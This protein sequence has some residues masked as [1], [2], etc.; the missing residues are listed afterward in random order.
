VVPPQAL[1]TRERLFDVLAQI[2]PVVFEG[3]AAEQLGRPDGVIVLDGACPDALPGSVPALLTPTLETQGPAADSTDRSIEFSSSK[4]VA[5]ALR[6]RILL[7]EQPRSGPVPAFGEHDEALAEVD[8]QPVW[9]RSGQGVSTLSTLAIEELEHDEALREQLRPGRFMGLVPLL[10]FLHEIC[11]GVGWSE[12]PL[13]ASFVID[14]PNLHWPSYGFLDYAELI[15]H[16]S[17]HRYHVGF[18]MVPLD[19][20]FVNRRAAELVKANGERLS[21]LVHGNDHVAQELGRLDT[22]HDAVPAIAQALRRVARFERRSGVRVRRVMAPPHGACSEAALRAMFRLGFDAACISRP[23]PWRDDEPPDGA[24]VGGSPPGRAEPTD[25]AYV[26]WSPPG[27]AEPPDG[28]YVGG[29]PPG[30]ADLPSWAALSRWHP[31]ELVAG[32]LPILPRHHLDGPRDELVFRALLRQPLIIYG[33]HWDFARGLDL[34]AEAADDIN[35]LGDVRWRPLDEIA[36]SNYST[37]QGHETLAVHM[38]SRRVRLD[39]PEGVAA[40][41]VHTSDVQGEP[42]WR[43]VACATGVAS[44][45]PTATD[46]GTLA[47]PADVG[48]RASPADV[49]WAPMAKVRGGWESKELEVPAPTRIELSLAPHQPLRAEALPRLASGVWPITR[50]VL[51]ESRDRVRPLLGGRTIG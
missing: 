34:L 31:A 7:E 37:K 43:N 12:A 19:G 42:L 21:L 14:D 36:A 4:H 6:G 30:R 41:T 33:H 32:G 2:F 8:G 5:R 48:W 26:G 27:R 10:H 44:E 1:A 51:V 18:A 23:H 29:S 20:W 11:D 22:D 45:A 50:R 13:Q 15:A 47:S 35:R 39:V 9:W 49:G 46:M 38:H 16:A 17:A 40:V 24:Y 3:R 25:G 28:A